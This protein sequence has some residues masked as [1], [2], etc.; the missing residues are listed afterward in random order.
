MLHKWNPY[1]SLGT[2]QEKTAFRRQ[3]G[4][5]PRSKEDRPG[6]WEPSLS[7]G[8]MSEV[9]A[10][11]SQQSGK[12]PET[13]YLPCSGWLVP[14]Q[15]FASRQLMWFLGLEEVWVLGRNTHLLSQEQTQRQRAG[16]RPSRDLGATWSPG[17][18][19]QSQQVLTF[20]GTEKALMVQKF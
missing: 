13:R 1:H 3:R 5:G 7:L 12:W 16:Q 6:L 17:I 2:A 19:L 20:I 11:V 10:R 8:L 15:E 18:H 14:T 4:L 9:T